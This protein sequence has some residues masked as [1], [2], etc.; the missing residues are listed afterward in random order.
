MICQDCSVI[1][2]EGKVKTRLRIVYE[3][4]TSERN[5]ENLQISSVQSVGE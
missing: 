3:D 4:V 2:R 5:V 1:R